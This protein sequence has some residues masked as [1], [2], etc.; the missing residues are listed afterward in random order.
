MYNPTWKQH[1]KGMSSDNLDTALKSTD[2]Y[3]EEKSK[4]LKTSKKAR[5][6][7][8][9]KI[10]F[11]QKQKPKWVKERNEAKAKPLKDA[12][13]ELKVG[14]KFDR[15]LKP[16]PGFVL[17]KPEFKETTDSGIY[18]VNDD[19]AKMNTNTGVVLAI[20]D[21]DIT[22]VKVTP[23]PV[24]QGDRVMFKKGLPGLEVDI[25]GEYCLL[26]QWSDLLGRIL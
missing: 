20:G 6:W 3:Q 13:K 16:M 26:M 18:V 12:I 15:G 8:K 22:K 17:I 14:G 24:K 11:Y 10:E 2:A 25:K 4:E 1:E 5:N 9:S 21:E 19:N 23:P 7:E